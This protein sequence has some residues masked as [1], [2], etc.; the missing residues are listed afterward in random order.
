MVT[1]KGGKAQWHTNMLHRLW[2]RRKLA[3]QVF[4]R[5]KRRIQL[6][7]M[8]ISTDCDSKWTR[9]CSYWRMNRNS[10]KVNVTTVSANPVLSWLFNCLFTCRAKTLQMTLKQCFNF[11]CAVQLAVNWLSTEKC[12]MLLQRFKH[13]LWHHVCQNFQW[14][15]YMY[16]VV[17]N[18]FY[19]YVH[20]KI[21]AQISS[22]D[23]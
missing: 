23:Q 20:I 13:V 10:K 21:T 8:P 15:A 9:R 7:I 18:F 12:W 22:Y 6:V 3:I 16:Y 4:S 1:E 5:R 2:V 14:F 19:V 17:K 11:A